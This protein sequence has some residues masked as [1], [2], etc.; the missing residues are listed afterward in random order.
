MHDS[1]V[2]TFTQLVLLHVHG[3]VGLLLYTT[4]YAVVF[5][6]ELLLVA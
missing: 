1:V 3:T 6:Q 4:S 5:M 2:H